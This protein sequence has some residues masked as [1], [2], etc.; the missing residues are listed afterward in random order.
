[1]SGKSGV[2]VSINA[3]ANQNI[4]L[5]FLNGAYNNVR[6]TFPVDIVII[7]WDGRALGVPPY[8]NYNAPVLVPAGT[9]FEFSVARRFDAM[10]RS[11]T[12]VSG[13][14]TVQFI[15][16]LRRNEVRA[17]ARIPINI[18]GGGPQPGNDTVTITRASFSFNTRKGIGTLDLRATSN[19]TDPVSLSA[20]G[21][22]FTNV[23]LVRGRATIKNLTQSPFPVT[24]TSTGGGS[25]IANGPI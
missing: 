3:Q 21:V 24:V 20:S 18:A 16:T 10:I 5:R 1:M 25:A 22:G 2:Q 12:A 13:F 4:L 15:D 7:A 8:G 11:A 19:S 6:V 23:P 14:A 17:T 9:T